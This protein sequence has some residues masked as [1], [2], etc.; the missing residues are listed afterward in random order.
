MRRFIVTVG[1]WLVLA[2]VAAAQ[3]TPLVAQDTALT[4][5]T[6]VFGQQVLTAD[7]ILLNSGDEAYSD[8]SLEA[9]VFDADDQQIG[10]GFGFLVNACGAALLPGFALQPGESQGFTITLELYEDDVTADHVEITAVGTPSEPKPSAAPAFLS[11]ITQVTN[12]EVSRIEWID[13]DNLRY[14]AGCWRDVFTE[15]GWYEYNVR[16][17]VQRSVIHPKVQ[18]ITDALRTQLG[19]VDDLYF[20]GSMLSY[21]PDPNGRRMVY[22]TELHTIITAEPDGSF[23]RVLFE[24]L[25]SHTL[26]NINWLRNGNFIASYYGAIGESVLY[27]TANVDGQVL[28]E[29]PLENI[30]SLIAPGASPDGTLIVIG[31]V[32][33]NDTPGYYL[34]RAAFAG[35]ELLYEA[36]LPG[37]NWPAPLFERDADGASYIYVAR[38]VDGEARLECFNRTTQ[39]VHDLSSLPLNLNTDERTWWSLSPENNT[40][41]LAADG[42]NG[43]LWLIEL[44]A[45]DSCE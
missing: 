7:G 14:G 16:T 30:P 37:N 25:S 43:G 17:G 31:A 11:G 45:L 20:R 22:Q 3:D 5:Q 19:L 4:T 12:R 18:F 44:D 33:E 39:E 41:A 10:E 36:E 35:V 42:V 38:P 15:L 1:C 21:D 32:D 6:D 26:Q 9:A 28:S 13:E 29:G 34:K 40:I 23:K 8:V 24:T 2:G 27:F